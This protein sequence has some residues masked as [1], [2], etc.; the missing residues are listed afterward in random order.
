MQPN[1]GLPEEEQQQ[2]QQM[3]AAMARRQKLYKTQMCRH[4]LATGTCAHGAYCHFAHSEDELRPARRASEGEPYP[5]PGLG[6]SPTEAVQQ[7]TWTYVPFGDDPAYGPVS[8]YGTDAAQQPREQNRHTTTTTTTT[9]TL[10]TPEQQI[11]MQ[12]HY[13]QLR[14]KTRMCRH[15]A[16]GGR[17]PRGT[18]CGFAHSESELRRPPNL[19][20]MVSAI[21]TFGAGLGAQQQQSPAS[22]TQQQQQSTWGGQRIALTPWPQPQPMIVGGS[23]AK[24]GRRGPRQSMFKTRLCRYA[25]VGAPEQCPRGEAC[26]FAHSETE[27]RAVPRRHQPRPLTD[28]T[29]RWKGAIFAAR[30]NRAGLEALRDS[31]LRQYRGRR[32]RSPPTAPPPVMSAF[33]TDQNDDD[34]DPASAMQSAFETGILL[35]PH[36]SEDERP[37]FPPGAEARESTQVRYLCLE[38]E[39][40]YSEE[41]RRRADANAQHRNWLLMARYLAAAVDL[42]QA[43]LQGVEP[44][45]SALVTTPQ[46]VPLPDFHDRVQLSAVLTVLALVRDHTRH[47]RDEAISRCESVVEEQREDARE[48][49]EALD[50][51][52]QLHFE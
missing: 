40:C 50:V 16:R 17:C 48:G 2:Q 4:I 15:V 25:E 39:C 7:A 49:L 38:I 11:A 14:Y 47:A 34:E 3:T 28:C 9:T 1:G 36:L 22:P 5:I 30:K 44:W 10:P 20:T 37:P 13:A 26:T 43:A 27:L 24:N 35:E 12:A 18:S 46:D 23:P 42:L 21:Q 31:L 32:L 19:E 33:V 51:L 6:L 8:P 52:Q 41:L 45:H 29:A